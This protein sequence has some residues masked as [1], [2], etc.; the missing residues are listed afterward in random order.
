MQLIRDL[1]GSPDALASA[2]T[3]MIRM[4]RAEGRMEAVDKFREDARQRQARSRDRK[5]APA[6]HVTSRDSGYIDN[7]TNKTSTQERSRS[8]VS[9]DRH[10]TDLCGAFWA[11]L[12]PKSRERSSR[13]QV[14]EQWK[15]Q[16]CEQI[17][18]VV[19]AGLAA[20]QTSQKWRDGFAEGGHRWL[21]NRQWENPPQPDAPAA[22]RTTQATMQGIR[23]FVMGG[24]DAA[25]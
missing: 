5:R 2:V 12:P 8:P 9:R 25:E 18:P 20:W 13:K 23:D 11:A 7:N 17:A 19:M 15:R 3:A 10:V 21:K 4:A 16:G 6:C 22:S 14:A 1:G 24:S